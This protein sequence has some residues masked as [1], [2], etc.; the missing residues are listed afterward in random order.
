[1]TFDTQAEWKEHRHSHTREQKNR[2]TV[3]QV[4]VERKMEWTQPH[5]KG[6]KPEWT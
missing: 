5:K 3:T 2:T 6:R 4:H 1:M